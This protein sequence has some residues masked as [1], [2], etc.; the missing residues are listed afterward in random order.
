MSLRE[1]SLVL[2]MSQ[3]S[4]QEQKRE[5]DHIA[6]DGVG[7]YR[8]SL[9]LKE[10]TGIY[11]SDSPKN[12]SLLVTRLIQMFR[13]QEIESLSEYYQ[14]LRSAGAASPEV[15]EFVSSMTTNT[16]RFFRESSHFKQLQQAI[17]GL[18]EIKSQMHGVDA[19]EIRVWCAAASTGQEPYTIAMVIQEELS[20]LSPVKNWRLKML[21][22]DI[23][24]PSLNKAVAG[25]YLE[26]EIEGVPAPYLKKYF[27][28]RVDSKG[29][30][31][32]V[33]HPGIASRITFAEINLVT[34][35]YPMKNPF[36]VVFC[37]NV[38]IYFD[39]ETAERV[40]A[41]IGRT[42]RPG[43]YLFLGHSES[44]AMKERDFQTISH[45]VYRK[46]RANS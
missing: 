33:I 24:T 31:K 7:F 9:L 12:R 20:R 15:A 36:D 26:K 30:K 29:Q 39:R 13:E 4:L 18:I 38:L 44:G 3:A 11:L 34:Q 5:M 23:D 43:G 37:R 19:T 14:I 2:P 28:D 8:L 35:T 27:V 41:N 22:S 40:V 10:L 45:S 21:A 6:G 42:V 25:V 16:T 1:R 32:F 46:R 17:S